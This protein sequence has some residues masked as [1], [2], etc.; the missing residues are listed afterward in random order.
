MIVEPFVGNMVGV[1]PAGFLERSARSV[2]A[3]IISI[4]DE[5]MTVCRPPR[6]A[7]GALSRPDIPSAQDRRRRIRSPLLRPR[8]L[9][10]CSRR[11][12]SVPAGTLSGTVDAVP[13][14]LATL[15]HLHP[16]CNAA[17]TWARA[18]KRASTRRSRMRVHPPACSASVR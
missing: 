18:W 12:V 10:S 11:S 14:G 1:R 7:Q 15:Y 16:A 17:R 9:M 5:V 8:R 13:A 3:W 2:A 4:F 6:G